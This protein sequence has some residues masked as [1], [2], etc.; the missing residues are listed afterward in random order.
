MSRDREAVH[1]LLDTEGGGELLVAERAGVV[2]GRMIVAW[3]G[4]RGNLY[5]LAVDPEYRRRG[6]AR[7][8]VAE[9]ENRLR[10]RGATRLNALVA[11]ENAGAVGFWSAAG[12]RADAT[13]RFVKRL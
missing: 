8:L 4:W 6:I 5:R 7:C 12:C 1:H 11:R 3:D 9:A 13:R 2:E 10:Q